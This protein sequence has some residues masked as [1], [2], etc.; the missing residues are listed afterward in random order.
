MERM[1]LAEGEVEINCPPEVPLQG[2]QKLRKVRTVRMLNPGL[3]SF[4]SFLTFP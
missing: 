2:N 3:L 4:L 1:E